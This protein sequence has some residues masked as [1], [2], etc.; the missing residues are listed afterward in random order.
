V[1]RAKEGSVSEVCILT[2]EY[3]KNPDIDDERGGY[4]QEPVTPKKTTL[5]VTNLRD[6]RSSFE[7]WRDVN[8]LGG[9]NM[10][11][12]SGRVARKNGQLGGRFSYNGRFW[13][14]EGKEVIISEEVQ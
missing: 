4:W 5:E 7:S 2:L 1:C 12:R 9:G 11:R 6:A 14:P 3:A 8:G 10:T 13:N